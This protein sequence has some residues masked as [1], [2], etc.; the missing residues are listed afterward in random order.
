MTKKKKKKKAMAESQNKNNGNPELAAPKPDSG[1][2]RGRDFCY[3]ELMPFE[4][5]T[6]QPLIREYFNENGAP[7]ELP[8][9]DARFHALYSHMNS[10][11]IV[12]PHV[13]YSYVGKVFA[14]YDGKPD[15]PLD[16]MGEALGYIW[17]HIQRDTSGQPCLFIEHIY[18]K[19]YYRQYHE[20][21][22]TLVYISGMYGLRA[23]VQNVAC[24]VKNVKRQRDWASYGFKVTSARMET[25][26]S[27]DNL[28]NGY[29]GRVAEKFADRKVDTWA[30]ARAVQPNPSEKPV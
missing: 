5:I 12:N 25:K 18:V 24:D 29:F 14:C 11:M 15:Y 6:I 16:I 9:P 2:I 26:C 27:V 30:A 28:L 4:L 23:R 1:T 3:M 13:D 17:F 20:I 8:I 22:A 19:E 10:S 7:D 21:H